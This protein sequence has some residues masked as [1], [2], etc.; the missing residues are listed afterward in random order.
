DLL[1][2]DRLRVGLS[3]RELALLDREDEHR[4]RCEVEENWTV[5]D[6]LVDL[7]RLCE[8][9]VDPAERLAEEEAAVPPGR[10]RADPAA[11]DHDDLRPSPRQERRRR[12]TGDP[13]ADDDGVRGQLS[14]G[15]P[16]ERRLRQNIKPAAAAPTAAI[17]AATAPPFLV[18]AL[19]A[20]ARAFCFATGLASV[21][22]SQPRNAFR[23]L[24]TLIAS[25]L[26]G[27]RRGSLA[28]GNVDRATEGD[29]T[30]LLDR[31]RERRVRSHAIGDGLDRRLRVERDDT[32]LDKVGDMR[33]DH[34][35]A[36]ELAVARLVDGFHP[37]RGLVLHDRPPVGDP[38]EGAGDDVVAVLLARRLFGEADAR[39]LR[40]GVDRARH[41]AVVDDG[42]MAHR[43]FGSDLGLAEGRM[44]ELPVAGTIAGGIDVWNRGSPV[45]V[46][47]DALLAVEL[48]SDLL[49]PE[50][51]DVG[52]AAGRDEHQVALLRLAAEVD[53]EAVAGVLDL[54]A[55]R[56][57]VELD[58][59]LLELLGEL[60]GCIV[61]LEGDE[62]R[63]HLDDR[64]F[65][66]EPRERGGELA[67]DDAAAQNDD[68]ARHFGLREKTCRVDTAL[69]VDALDGRPERRR[70]RRDDGALERDVLPA[71][72]G[73][74]VR[75][76]EAADALHPLDSVRLE[77]RRDAAGQLLDD[78]L[79]PL[80]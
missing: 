40:V 66:A 4:P 56:L 37:A 33:P 79:L 14:V 38:R 41:A 1:P 26:S 34:D 24:N 61:V 68:A 71:L 58:A 39:D 2:A 57:E 8:E 70:S 12:A 80:L 45:L 49:E 78:A 30:G 62:L 53:A 5:R 67:T 15:E 10:A 59:A 29:E 20:A 35:Q 51:F 21:I 52:P 3:S 23:L 11:V 77:E 76:L 74:C 55:L 28:G 69:R 60:L 19:R 9:V 47:G 44:R 50:P 22:T 6:L 42:L 17:E 75:V 16:L 72:D 43:V 54:V 64:H 36:E 73:E 65:A 63:E 27:F 25:L 48:D 32:G 31:L 13:R 46:R 18:P 7:E